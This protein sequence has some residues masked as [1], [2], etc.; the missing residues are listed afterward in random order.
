MLVCSEGHILQNY[1][2]ETTELTET[3]GHVLRQRRT[4]NTKLKTKRQRANPAG[5]SDRD[6]WYTL[7]LTGRQSIMAIV[8]V[9][10]T[11]KVFNFSFASR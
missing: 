7:G 5:V 9:S 1:R 10:C 6:N 8:H 11:F 3:V 4:G 2:N